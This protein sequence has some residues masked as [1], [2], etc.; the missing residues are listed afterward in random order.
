MIN[1]LFFIAPD[2]INQLIN[3]CELFDKACQDCVDNGGNPDYECTNDFGFNFERLK[4]FAKA[5]PTFDYQ[6]H[7]P[8]H[9]NIISYFFSDS[10]NYLENKARKEYEKR[11]AFYDNKY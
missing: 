2:N 11:M 6:K 9:K 1:D 5:N 3:A 8:N 7:L 4:K 10:M